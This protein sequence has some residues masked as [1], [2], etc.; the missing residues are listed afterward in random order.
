[1]QYKRPRVFRFGR[2]WVFFVVRNIKEPLL[3]EATTSPVWRYR[4][5]QAGATACDGALNQQLGLWSQEQNKIPPP[6]LRKKDSGKGNPAQM[7]SG[8]LCIS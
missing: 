3:F 6:F 1:M 8:L 5:E 2:L 7:M 4:A